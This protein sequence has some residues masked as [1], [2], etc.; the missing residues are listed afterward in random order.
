MV[1]CTGLEN[2]QGFTPLVGSNPTLSARMKKGPA[3]TLFYA[4]NNVFA[5]D[6]PSDMP[7]LPTGSAQSLDQSRQ[8]FFFHTSTVQQR[9][10]NFRRD[11]V[12]A[13]PEE[14][15]HGGNL[16]GGN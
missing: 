7:F 8:P 14:A 2:R 9:F 12:I 6:L 13:L 15:D 11:G 16:R 1:E 4:R 5:A 10:Q 3:G